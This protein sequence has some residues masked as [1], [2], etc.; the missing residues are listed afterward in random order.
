RNNTSGQCEYTNGYP[1][2]TDDDTL[3]CPERYD[4]AVAALTTAV[5]TCNDEP[6]TLQTQALLRFGIREGVEVMMLL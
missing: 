1:D 5:A 2:T 6:L 4:V 3:N